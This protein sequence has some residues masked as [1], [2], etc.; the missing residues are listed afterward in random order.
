MI[1]YIWH[2]VAAQLGIAGVFIAG[3]L[4][5]AYFFPPFRRL[6]LSAAAVVLGV[7]A[8]YAK[9]AS[10]AARRAKERREAEEKAAVERGERARADAERDAASGVRD[11]YDRSK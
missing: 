2:S 9:G 1:D 4:A 7:A 11:G 8:I 10:D 5:V 3:L 6:A